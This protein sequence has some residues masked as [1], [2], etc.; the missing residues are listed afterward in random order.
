MQYLNIS[1]YRFVDIEKPDAAE[2]YLRALCNRLEI[3]G[4]ILLSHEGINLALAGMAENIQ[5]FHQAL[6]ETEHFKN[7][8]FKP[9]WSSKIPFRR[10]RIRVKK[11]I[12]N[13]GVDSIRPLTKT[14]QHLSAQEFK[15][16]L[17]ENRDITVLDTRN[18][19]EIKVGTFAKA[20]DLNIE[21]FRDFPEAAKSMP[22][23]IKEK[24]IVMFCTGGIRCEKASALFMD[25]GFKNVYQLDGGIIKYFEECGGAHWNGE[26]FVFDDRIA[27]QPDLAPTKKHYC[28]ACLDQLTEE[29]YQSDK[30]LYNH[31]CPHCYEVN[32]K[33]DAS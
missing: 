31:Y 25:Y 30:F 3:K 27:V 29:E 14:A 26:C 21:N 9:S 17:D 6:N 13:M 12:I 28:L 32:S 23:E 11:E 24:P 20:I 19:Y 16:W 22:Q 18:D 33:R 5:Q 2:T 7:M 8:E 10:L 4:T 15:K 1:G